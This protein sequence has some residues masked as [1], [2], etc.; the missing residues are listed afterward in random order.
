MEGPLIFSPTP[1]RPRLLLRFRPQLMTK[2]L[3]VT[4]GHFQPREKER[5]R[6]GPEGQRGA[7]AGLK[8][9]KA[10][11]LGVLVP[12]RTCSGTGPIMGATDLRAVR[13]GRTTWVGLHHR[14]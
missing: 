12:R 7:R 1:R 8:E 2:S 4:D 3:S 6:R 9:P 11:G 14:G 5:G 13:G 10:L